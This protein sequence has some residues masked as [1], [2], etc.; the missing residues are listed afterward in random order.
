VALKA[1]QFVWLGNARDDLDDLAIYSRWRIH[2][3]NAVGVVAS[4]R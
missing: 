1:S 3:N 4:W 2:K